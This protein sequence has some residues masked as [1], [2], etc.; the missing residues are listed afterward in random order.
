MMTFNTDAPRDC[1]IVETDDQGVV[2]AFHEKVSNPPGRRANGAVYML[3]PEVL[4][5]LEGHTELIDFST[6]VLPQYMG[7]IATWHNYGVHRDIGTLESLRKAQGDA[8]TNCDFSERDEWQE[9][10]ESTPVFKTLNEF[11][12]QPGAP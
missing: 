1:G 3:E 2:V 10:F 4:E 11:I 7:R 9:R 8:P 6:Q 5:W 12:F